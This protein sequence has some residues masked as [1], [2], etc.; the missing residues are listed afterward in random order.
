[1]GGRLAGN[2]LIS[3]RWRQNGGPEEDWMDAWGCVEVLADVEH[4]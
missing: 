3:N 1:M 4:A 2:Y